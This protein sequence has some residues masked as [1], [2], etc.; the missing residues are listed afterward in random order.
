[1][2]E[3]KKGNLKE[4]PN[5]EEILKQWLERKEKDEKHKKEQIL[6]E[7]HLC[8]KDGN[9]LDLTEEEYEKVKPYL[10][11]SNYYK[12]ASTSAIAVIIYIMTGIF[13]LVG[14]FNMICYFDYPRSEN[15][16]FFISG[17]ISGTFFLALGKIVQSLHNIDNKL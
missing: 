2:D 12:T 7:N 11:V 8:D 15:M 1:M 6:M 16:V 3:I 9:S 14:L 10:V 5:K 4:Q 17:I 13:Y